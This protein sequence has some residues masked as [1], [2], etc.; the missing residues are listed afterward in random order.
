ME[1]ETETGTG[2][3]AVG[4]KRTV[5]NFFMGTYPEDFRPTIDPDQYMLRINAA[6]NTGLWK[7]WVDRRAR[8]EAR[9][10][11]ANNGYR[12]FT[13]VSCDRN[14]LISRFDYTIQFVR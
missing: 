12:D 3:L 1:P 5:Y 6:T 8:G 4:V 10:F 11:A 2:R 9:R 14:R 7:F 13:I